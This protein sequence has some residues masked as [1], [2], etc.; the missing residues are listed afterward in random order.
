MGKLRHGRGKGQPP[1]LQHPW[2]QNSKGKKKKKKNQSTFSSPACWVG[3]RAQGFHCKVK[4]PS[5]IPR[6]GKSWKTLTPKHQPQ[7][8]KPSPGLGKPKASV[9][10]INRNK[11][12]SQ[13]LRKRD[14]KEKKKTQA[15]SRSSWKI[16]VAKHQVTAD[17]S[18]PAPW[19]ASKAPSPKP[20]PSRETT[21]EQ[22]M[23]Q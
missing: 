15:R 18:L 10:H 7:P 17:R 3:D 16:A 14:Q 20:L 23:E 6:A 21:L 11:L 13:T 1:C 12:E 22:A 9:C 4:G 8:E 2:D 19:A 5:G